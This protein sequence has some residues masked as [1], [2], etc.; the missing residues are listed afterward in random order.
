MWA[1]NAKF[2]HVKVPFIIFKMKIYKREKMW[3]KNAEFVRV[4]F[5]FI[6][7]KFSFIQG[8]N[9]HRRCPLTQK[10][11]YPHVKTLAPLRGVIVSLV[12]IV[13]VPF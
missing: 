12:R 11:V 7:F 10:N 6:I 1:K 5:P 4:K 13:V 2:V 9:F 8:H 3:A